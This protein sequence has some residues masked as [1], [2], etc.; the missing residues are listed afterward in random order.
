[1]TDTFHLSFDGE[2]IVDVKT[3]SNDQPIYYEAPAMGS[4]KNMPELW[5]TLSPRKWLR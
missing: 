3:S 1:M 2:N 5:P 4:K